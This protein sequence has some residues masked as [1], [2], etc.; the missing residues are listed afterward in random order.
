MVWLL[1]ALTVLFVVVWRWP[2]DAPFPGAARYAPLHLTL[3]TGSVIIAMLVFGLAWNAYSRERPGNVMILAC[4]LL[5]TGLI[6]FVHTLSYAGM[7]DFITPSGQEKAINFWLAARLVSA[8]AFLAVALRAWKPLARPEMRWVLLGGSLAIAAVVVWAGI[9]HQEAWPRTFIVGQGLTTFKVATEYLIIAI[10]AVTAVIVFRQA[11]RGAEYDAPSLFAAVAISVLSELALTLY[12]DATDIFNLLGHAYKVVAY[13]FLYRAVFVLSVHQPFERVKQVEAALRESEERYRQIFN[14]VLDGVYLLDVVE[15]GRFR[16][17]QMNPA[18]ETL[19]GI[20]RAQ[21]L[22]NWEDEVALAEPIAIITAKLRRC[23]EAGQPTEEVVELELPSGRRTFQSSLFPARDASGRVHRIVGITR[24]VTERVA[25]DRTRAQLASIVESSSDAIFS[26][27]LDGTIL[28]WNRG[29]EAIYGYAASE[30]IGQSVEILS[31][32]GR[33]SD[34]PVILE[35]VARGDRVEHSET[36][37][38]RRDGSLIDISLAVSPIV[39]DR[40]MVTAASSISHDI[41]DRMRAQVALRESEEQHRRFVEEDIAGV[42]ITAVDGRL[43]ACNPAFA[44]MFGCGSVEAALEIDVTTL[45][46]T[47]QDREAFLAELRAEHRVDRREMTLRRR[48]GVPVRSIL[49]AVGEFDAAGDLVSIRTYHIDV[50]ERRHLEEQL[51]QAQKVEAIGQLAGGIAHDFN[52]LLTAINGYADFLASDMPP[53]DPRRTDVTEIRNAGGRAAALTRQLLAFSRRQVLQPVVLD[54]NIVMEGLAPMLRRLIGEDVELR[55]HGAPD[56]RHV[57][58]DPAQLEQVILN[59]AINARD[60]MPRGGTLT[61]E[62][63]AVELDDDYLRTHPLASPGRY[64]QLTVS[65]TGTGMDAETMEHMF[66]PFFTTKPEGHG[67]GLGLATV[68]GIVTQSGGHV[69]AYSEP[70]HGTTF[71]VYLPEVAE[72]AVAP[73]ASV[74]G[75]ARGGSETILLVEDE[76]AV[77]A[78]AERI[79]AGLGYTLLTASNGTEALAAASAHESPIDLLVTDVIMPGL[80]GSELSQRLTTSRPALLT[81]YMS[82]YTEAAIGQR[83]LLPQGAGFLAKPFSPDGL[84]RAVR[85]ALDAVRPVATT[86]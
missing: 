11:R 31:P 85:D 61:L 82:G 62:T 67:T 65:D 19:T 38:R 83:G 6:D 5:A 68:Y 2:I 10:L 26:K 72:T 58:A 80:N 14:N 37:R 45:Y 73:A 54:I 51:R 50:T 36:V 9:F 53:D 42:C 70:G 27:S 24:D 76:V 63:A 17:L 20:P 77:R 84:G 7:P 86:A 25:A 56:L 44:C 1:A 43:L 32:P 55:T 47:P 28:T 41:T 8:L 75:P 49:T 59:L 35:R 46:A 33:P 3:E 12:T 52:N 40:G 22:G 34:I 18:L 69:A 48:D 21:I 71:R 16:M 64:V 78:F 66:E 79:L 29:A 60:A 57:R 23:V 74:A 81:L 15:D 30:A 13:A 4:A 39:D